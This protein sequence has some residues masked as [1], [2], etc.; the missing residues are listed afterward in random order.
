MTNRREADCESGFLP[1]TVVTHCRSVP[2]SMTYLR[3]LVMIHPDLSVDTGHDLECER[4][5][6]ALRG[7]S[8]CLLFAEATVPAAQ[9]WQRQT[10]RKPL[11]G[12]G[13]WKGLLSQPCAP[14][15]GHGVH[16]ATTATGAVHTCP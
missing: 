11:S 5:A 13:G 14:R 15:R 6:V 3:H 16:L 9:Y 1:C 12:G 2:A 7:Y 10:G 8:S 4:V